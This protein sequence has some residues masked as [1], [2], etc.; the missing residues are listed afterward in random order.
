MIGFPTFLGSLFFL[1]LIVVLYL[2]LHLLSLGLIPES[3][4]SLAGCS[5]VKLG[6]KRGDWELDAGSWGN[7]AQ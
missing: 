1:T 6:N 3:W 4:I 2:G 7:H 5:C